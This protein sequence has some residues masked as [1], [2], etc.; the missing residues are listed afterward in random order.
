MKRR[1]FMKAMGALGLTTIAPSIFS[2]KDFINRVQ[3]SPAIQAATI[4]LSTKRTPQVINI[5]LY[6]GASELAGN[7]TNIR[8]LNKASQSPYSNLDDRNDRPALN[9]I[10]TEFYDEVAAQTNPNANVGQ[11]TPNGCWANAGGIIME[12][13]LYEGDMTIYRTCNRRKNNTRAHRLSIFS[14]QKGTLDVDSAP[15]LGTTL[16]SVIASNPNDY[17]SEFG[18]TSLEE[19]VMPMVSFEGEST[20]FAPDPNASTQLPLVLKPVGLS[21][22]FDNPYQRNNEPTIPNNDID[23]PP[24]TD[25]SGTLRSTSEIDCLVNKKMKARAASQPGDPDFDDLTGDYG[26]RYKKVSESFLNHRKLAATV[27]RFNDLISD[28]TTLPILPE[29]DPDGDNPDFDVVLFDRF[30]NALAGE[31]YTADHQD[32]P[33]SLTPPGVTPGII[34]TGLNVA[35]VNR[36]EIDAMGNTVIVYDTDGITPLRDKFYVDL[37]GVPIA[38]L[39]GSPLDTQGDMSEDPRFVGGP[40]VNRLVYPQNNRFA[41]L[42]RAA[43]TLCIH[44]PDTKLAMVGSPGLGGWDDHNSAMMSYEAR[45]QTLMSAVRAAVKHIKYSIDDPA[46]EAD[47]G[48]G[49]AN[50]TSNIIINIFTDFGRNANLNNSQGWDHGNNQNFYTLGGRPYIRDPDWTPATASDTVRPVKNADLTLTPNPAS[51]ELSPRPADALGKIVGS[52][53]IFGTAG[54]NRLFT[55]PAEA[56]D[57]DTPDMATLN[58][59]KGYTSA[60]YEF[61][62]QA[63]ASTIYSWFGVTNPEVLTK[64]SDDFDDNPPITRVGSDGNGTLAQESVNRSAGE[65]A[66]D[67]NV[68]GE[69]LSASPLSVK[70]IAV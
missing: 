15:G 44:N 40:G 27:Q 22:N 39:D 47:R 61:E 70:N 65:P 64:N 35:W 55:K 25:S 42:L 2:D 62:P 49:A 51:A 53:N 14:G 21:A 66:I 41:E 37:A 45:M 6:G 34:G 50:D 17:T 28:D 4:D 38:K 12:D 20:T 43:V 10:F 26:E 16:A 59:L 69:T 68:A 31:G 1:D 7:L 52:T 32:P 24:Y 13:M 56:T 19:L 58:A 30:I 18:V 57:L 23:C 60:S 11:V 36:T 46:V 29:R 33:Q 9:P 8:D 67:E 63:I 54:Q 5:F 3:A 48:V